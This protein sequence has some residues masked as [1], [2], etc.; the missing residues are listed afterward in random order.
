MDLLELGDS[1]IKNTQRTEFDNWLSR[2]ETQLSNFF[3]KLTAEELNELRFDSFFF[4]NILSSDVYQ[5][6]HQTHAQSEEFDFFL[7]LIA[8]SA[9]RLAQIG[10]DSVSQNIVADLPDSPSKFRLIALNQFALVEDIRTS[11]L[12]EFPKVL[13]TLDKSRQFEDSSNRQIVDVL[14]YYYKKARTALEK[15]GLPNVLKDLRRLYASKKLNVQYPFLAHQI[16]RD[17]LNDVDPFA[18]YPVEIRRERLEPSPSIRTLFADINQK[19]FDHPSIDRDSDN[20]WGYTSRHILDEVLIR[21]RGD[22][23]KAYGKITSH[24]KVLLYCY[25]NMKKHFFTSYAVFQTVVDSMKG[26]FSNSDYKPVFI[27]LGCGPMT[28]GLALADLIHSNSGKGINMS[29]VGVDISDA[30]I[31]RAKSFQTSRIFSSESSFNYF[32]NW[33][34]LEPAILHKF[35]GKNNPIIFNAS[36]LFASSSLDANDLGKY[37][38]SVSKSFSNIFFVFQ[39]PNRIDRN[40]KYEEFKKNLKAESIL[41]RAENIPYKAASKEANE[42]VSYEILKL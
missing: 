37:V 13:S 39:N 10:L 15:A 4:E 26:I 11:Y 41:K 5:D 19:F 6:F 30:M 21:G 17:L 36:Y 32:K 20:Y 22:F 7:N 42:D 3:Y 2:N 8:V 31:T 9:E 18:L 1:L 28:S 35:A 38:K 33:N 23:T 25:F 40:I 24:D 12:D 14:A 29:Y 27:D 34:D 16:L